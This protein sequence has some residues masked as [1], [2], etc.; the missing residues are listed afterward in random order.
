MDECIQDHVY[1]QLLSKWPQHQCQQWNGGNL[2]QFAM[3]TH[4]PKK[5]E[6]V[7]AYRMINSLKAELFF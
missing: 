2:D 4:A 3:T 5:K 1:G 7:D 6:G